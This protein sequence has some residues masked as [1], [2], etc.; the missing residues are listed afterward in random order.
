[1]KKIKSNFFLCLIKH[2]TMRKKV[3]W[4]YTFIIFSSLAMDIDERWGSRPYFFFPMIITQC[5][6]VFC[7]AQSIWSFWRRKFLPLQKK[8]LQF[9]CLQYLSFVVTIEVS[10]SVKYLLIS[11]LYL[12]FSQLKLTFPFFAIK[13]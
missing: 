5:E 11:Y 1:M 13:H 10:R 8:K 6:Y 9:S 7:V 3:A 2:N 4:I 12:I